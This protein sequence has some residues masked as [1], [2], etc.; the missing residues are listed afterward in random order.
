MMETV[1]ISKAEYEDLL[2]IMLWSRCLDE[3]GVDNWEGIDHA[4][5][6]YNLESRRIEDE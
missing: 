3:A 1:T 2:D 5:D 6:L 4:S